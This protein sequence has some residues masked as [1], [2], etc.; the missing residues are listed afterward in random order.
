MEPGITGNGML[1][2]RCANECR[3]LS[4]VEGKMLSVEG[5]MSRVEG[6]MSRVICFVNISRLVLP[7]RF[8]ALSK[9]Q[10]CPDLSPRV[11]SAL[12]HILLFHSRV[13]H[14]KVIESY[15][16]VTM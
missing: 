3:F 1:R 2:E 14:W 5:K 8:P 12:S 9:I 13:F 16:Q 4:R 7:A 6:K 11:S 15:I 10:E